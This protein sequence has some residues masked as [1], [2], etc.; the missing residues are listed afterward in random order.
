MYN[1]IFLSPAGTQLILVEWMNK[2]QWSVLTSLTYY[3]I[4]TLTSY[5]CAVPIVTLTNLIYYW[6]HCQFK[7]QSR[8]QK[9]QIPPRI[10]CWRKFCILWEISMLPFYWITILWFSFILDCQEAWNQMLYSTQ[11]KWSPPLHYLEII[12]FVSGITMSFLSEVGGNL[13]FAKHYN[14]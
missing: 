3:T 13:L 2:A 14:K 5:L 11:Q 12:Y 10:E 8:L 9:E 1:S 6:K 7:A 4:S